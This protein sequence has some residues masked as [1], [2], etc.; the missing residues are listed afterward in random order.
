[1][2]FDFFKKRNMGQSGDSVTSVDELLVFS[3][4]ANLEISRDDVELLEAGYTSRIVNR[5]LE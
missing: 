1:M 4:P 3:L 2:I 5:S